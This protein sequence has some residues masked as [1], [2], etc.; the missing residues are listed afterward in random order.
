MVARIVFA[1][2]GVLAALATGIVVLFTFGAVLAVLVTL[3]LLAFAAW[4]AQ[5]TGETPRLASRIVVVLLLFLSTAL[6]LYVATRLTL[7]FTDISGLVEPADQEVLAKAQQKIDEQV[8]DNAAFRLELTEGEITAL[9]QDQLAAVA[10][11]FRRVTID[12]VGGN[13]D[14]QIEFSATSRNDQV[15]IQGRMNVALDAGMIQFELLDADVGAVS[16]PGIARGFVEDLINP[17]T[18]KG[19]TE[20]GAEIQSVQL[21]DDRLV[22]VGSQQGGT[23]LS[24]ATLRSALRRQAASSANTIELSVREQFG[25]GVVDGRE[26][27]GSSY[28]VALGDSLAANVGV[29]S[30]REGYV[31]R[32]H[33]QLQE[34][35]GAQYGLRNFGV[36]G[37]TSASLIRTGQLDAAMEFI[38]SHE[39]SYVTMNIGANDLLGHLASSDCENGLSTTACND[40]IAAAFAAFEVNLGHIY[41]RLRDAAPDA[42][43]VF[44]TMYN[45][46]SLGLGGRFQAATDRKLSEFNAVAAGLARSHGILIADGFTPMQGTAAVTTHMVDNP[47]DIHPR[48]IGFDILTGALVEALP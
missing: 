38:S 23:L 35:D 17:F 32:F 1:I 22:V 16:V 19:L 41:G 5:T 4:S 27:E 8:S 29:K 15:T 9:V 18:E 42:T 26:S 6:T 37:E 46:F 14:G 2:L 25:P 44:M 36:S 43:I 47:P 34:R 11:P 39:V 3:L 7:A 33:K 45:P 10:A 48:G 13:E 28:Y 40:R 31:S 24:S 20:S 30:A 12:I 21:G